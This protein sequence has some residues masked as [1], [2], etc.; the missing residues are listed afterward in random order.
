MANEIDNLLIYEHFKTWMTIQA[1][2]FIIL[3]ALGVCWWVTF[4]RQHL[5]IPNKRTPIINHALKCHLCKSNINYL[6]TVQIQTF[7]GRCL[8]KKHAGYETSHICPP[9]VSIDTLLF[10]AIE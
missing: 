5:H 6:D 2:S 10:N 1:M 3:V 7:Y 4:V 8:K 9:N